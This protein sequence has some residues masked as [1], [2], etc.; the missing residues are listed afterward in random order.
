MS[1]EVLA[2]TREKTARAQGRL[3]GVL[4]V[5]GGALTYWLWSQPPPSGGFMNIDLRPLVYT[6]LWAFVIL[7]AIASSVL[8]RMLMRHQPPRSFVEPRVHIGALAFGQ[9]IGILVG[10]VG[11]SV[12]LEVL[13]HLTTN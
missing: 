8:V 11:A 9:I 12:G 4:F 3:V 5:L 7:D 6:W 2:L 1:E 13:G 10:G